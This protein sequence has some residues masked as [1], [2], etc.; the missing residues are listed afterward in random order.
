MNESQIRTA[1]ELKRWRD[2]NDG[3]LYFATN[4][5]KMSPDPWQ[6]N[7]FKNFSSPDPATRRIAMKAC[8][9]VGKTAALAVCILWFM[10]TQGEP[11]EHPKGAAT[12]IT[13]DN[14]DDNL[15]PEISK[16][17][18][19]SEF[20]KLAF[21][22]TKSRFFAVNH[23]ETWFF[24]KRTWPKGGEASQQANTL[25]GLHSKY[26]LFVVDESGDI[27]DA[28]LAAA[29]A[30][31]TGTEEG[32]FQKIL[33]AGNPTRLDGPLYRA[34]HLEKSLWTVIEITGDPDN[35]A[36]STRQS[37]EWAREQIKRY[38]IDSPWVLVNVFGTFP[39]S[40]INALLS[41]VQVRASIDRRLSKQ[42]YEMGQKRIGVDVA[43]FGDD[44]SVLFPR[45]GL[46]TFNIVELSGY[47]TTEIAD[48]VINSKIKWG[49][50]L[51][52]V[53]G[54]GGYGGGVCDSMVVRGYNPIEVNFSG[55]ATDS[56]YFNR[57]A[58]MYFRLAEWV[59]GRGQLPE[60]EKLRKELCATTYTSKNGKII[61]SPK[62][63]IKE[64][65]GFSPDRSDALALTFA[66]AEE[67]G[68]YTL[69]GEMLRA[70][71][72]SCA[73]EYDPYSPERMS[74]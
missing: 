42:A 63:L 27:P 24:S 43:R 35:P 71:N 61:L 14:I 19:R 72:G 16:W 25:A 6:V 28:V 45:Q 2:P 60:D 13:E 58:E 47:R 55:K 48:R 31:L 18:S 41:D 8:K 21:K 53:D 15:W 57:R 37:I 38:G 22:W 65:L 40:S 33:Q 12:S 9:G 70:K 54:T 29:D 44:M 59:K 64:N 67:P 62:E 7:L 30:G 56:R 3:C 34:C 32:R 52:F 73:H 20:L 68:R 17:Q 5:L 50:E 23:P 69:E 11:G 51:E 46:K 74:G 1:Y 4:E 49:S 66:Q 10:A 39:S 36:R 26:L